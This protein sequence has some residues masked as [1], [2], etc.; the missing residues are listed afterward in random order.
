ME[1][2]KKKKEKIEPLCLS[3]GGGR[4]EKEEG[5]M[6]RPRFHSVYAGGRNREDGKGD[7]GKEKE[8]EEGG[9]G[10]V[11]IVAGG[12]GG[13]GGGGVRWGEGDPRG[14]TSLLPRTN[15]LRLC[16]KFGST[17]SKVCLIRSVRDGIS[18]NFYLR[19]CFVSN[20]FWYFTFLGRNLEFLRI[21]IYVSFPFFF[22]FVPFSGGRKF[23]GFLFT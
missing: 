8:G 20:F 3:E 18:P 19:E 5:G 4:K 7:K 14:S 1:E 22:W 15:T 12:E 23:S 13:G 17:Q 11:R 9:E 21:F 10:G 2:K 16:E 6:N